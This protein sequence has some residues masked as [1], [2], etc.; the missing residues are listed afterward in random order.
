MKRKILSVFIF[1][2]LLLSIS[3]QDIFTSFLE[4]NP[5][6]P[7]AMVIWSEIGNFPLGGTPAPQAVSIIHTNTN[8]IIAGYIDDTST[9]L[10]KKYSPDSSTWVD[11]S[12]ASNNTNPDRI[13]LYKLGNEIYAAKSESTLIFIKKYTG[14]TGWEDIGQ[15]PTGTI[16]AIKIAG[17]KLASGETT[18]F[19]LYQESNLIYMKKYTGG[20]NWVDANAGAGYGINTV[21]T[22]C[23]SPSVAS[24]GDSSENPG[25]YVAFIS[26][27]L[28]NQVSVRMY[29]GSSWTS[30]EDPTLGHGVNLTTPQSY[31]AISITDNG[32]AVIWEE[33]HS[34]AYR[35]ATAFYN[36]N[37]W[38]NGEYNLTDTIGGLKYSSVDPIG[39]TP[40]LSTINGNPYA[41]WSEKPSANNYLRGKYLKT[42]PDSSIDPV[43]LTIDNNTHIN[44]NDADDVGANIDSTELNGSIYVMFWDNNLLAYK[45]LKSNAY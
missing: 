20:T 40:I 6:T 21:S 7:D 13:S 11:L 23:L 15:I 5:I 38:Q 14:D 39:Y 24:T 2:I 29:D 45:I 17:M 8:E 34:P 4:K 30:I 16:T 27:A 19:L 9:F 12:W 1:F 33:N 42:S 36:G 28:P 18:L 26:N 41:I 43:W 44:I 35:L 32:V 37:N 10:I 25:I 31:P 22:L 3:C